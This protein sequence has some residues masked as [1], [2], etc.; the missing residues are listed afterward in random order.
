MGVVDYFT[1][2]DPNCT[3][4][5][6]VVVETENDR[7]SK[8]SRYNLKKIFTIGEKRSPTIIGISVTEVAMNSRKAVNCS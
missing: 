3:L 4:F 8:T 5:T 7:L 6:E 2:T 1:P